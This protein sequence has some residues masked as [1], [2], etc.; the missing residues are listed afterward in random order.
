MQR[1]CFSAFRRAQRH[2]LIPDIRRSAASFHT[3]MSFQSGL[4]CFLCL[5]DSTRRLTP[6]DSLANKIGNF[7]SECV[8]LQFFLKAFGRCLNNP[9]NFWKRRWCPFRDNSC[10]VRGAVWRA[11]RPD[12]DCPY[13]INHNASICSALMLALI[14]IEVCQSGSCRA[15][16]VSPTF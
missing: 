1:A 15:F 14:S 12:F 5:C 2:A 10:F 6:V 3:R 7:H 13:H 8:L 11:P 4:V 9:V 16:F